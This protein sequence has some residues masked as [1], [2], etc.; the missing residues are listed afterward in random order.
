VISCCA[1]G[2]ARVWDAKNGRELSSLRTEDDYVVSASIR[3]ND[4]FITQ[5]GREGGGKTCWQWRRRRP[6]YWWGPFCLW[7]MWV[8]LVL[9]VAL[10]YNLHLD[11]KTFREH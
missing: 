9:G 11:Q 8:V 5:S 6:E 10:G 1:D 7:E 3:S 4:M 2:V